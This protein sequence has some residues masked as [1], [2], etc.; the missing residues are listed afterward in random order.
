VFKG[1]EEN[2]VVFC[3]LGSFY[4]NNHILWLQGVT[5]PILI[6]TTSMVHTVYSALQFEI[7]ADSGETYLH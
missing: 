2:V 5:G 3:I 7:K 4:S 1:L 6:E